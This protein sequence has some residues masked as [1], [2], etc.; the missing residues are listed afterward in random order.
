M[1]R[2]GISHRIWLLL[3]ALLLTIPPALAQFGAGIQGTI[4]DPTGAVIPGATVT[5]TKAETGV[6]HTGKTS[7]DGFYRISELAP[8]T[9]AIK[10]EAK[11]FKTATSQI[12]VTAETV[13]G[14]KAQLH[15]CRMTE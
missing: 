6:A 12:K 1:M 2:A 4:K 14:F 7:G 5:A 10:V 8:G 13:A 11:G 9:Y 3:L 15:P